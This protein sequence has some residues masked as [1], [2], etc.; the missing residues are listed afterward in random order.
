MVACICT[1]ETCRGP[2][3]AKQSRKAHA[4]QHEG[5]IVQHSNNGVD[6][7]GDVQGGA[8]LRVRGNSAGAATDSGAVVGRVDSGA[9]AAANS[10]ATSCTT[11]T[12]VSSKVSEWMAAEC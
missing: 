2:D 7:C 10:K 1:I 9:G 4:G 12:S 8:G 3:K 5:S 11:G 6:T